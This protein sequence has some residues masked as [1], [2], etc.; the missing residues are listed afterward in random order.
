VCQ[1]GGMD[2]GDARALALALKQLLS[3]AHQVIDD[4]LP[5]PELVSRVTAHLGCEL[6]DLVCV[7]QTFPN[8]EHAN[9]QRG[10]DAYLGQ[11][12]E[13]FG[14]SGHGRDHTDIV[15]MLAVSARGYERYEIGAVDYTTLATGPDRTAE[16]I[17]LGL[18]AAT[19]PGGEPIV[20]ALRG[21]AEQY[22]GDGCRLDILAAHRP[23]AT[24]ARAEIERLMREHDVFRGQILTFGV[25]EH[26]GNSLVSFLPR[27]T[28]GPGEVVLPEGVLETVERHVVGVAEHAEALRAHGQH[29]KRG[30]LLH[31]PP[32]TGKTH[33]VRYLMGRLPEVTVIV[34]TGPAMGLVSQA[35]ALARRLQPAIVVVED[36]DLVA[37][38]RGMSPDG[39]SPVLFT[40]LDAMDGIGADADVTFV[41]TTNRAEVLEDALAN[42]PGRVDLAVE[43]PRPDARGRL[44][45]LELYGRELGKDLDLTPVVAATEGMTASFFKELMRRAVLVALRERG[46]LTTLTDAEVGTAL[47]EMLIGREALTRTLLGAGGKD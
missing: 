28:L 37:E 17:T 40:L 41:L 11:D 30:L 14:V 9:L 33:T 16:V 13:W 24:S 25:S 43:V 15:N 38:D 31:G 32:G 21:D 35:A 20:I 46:T 34:M 18:T 36:V 3:Q 22:G 5:A 12:A 6:K 44:A 29:L 2:N 45:L 47:E 8:W 19:A 39:N 1:S 4:S 23:G 26:R 10:V 7:T 42:R 27:P